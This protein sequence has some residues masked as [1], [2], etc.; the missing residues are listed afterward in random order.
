MCISRTKLLCIFSRMGGGACVSVRIISEM[1][2]RHK[3]VEVSFASRFSDD[4]VSRQGLF[5]GDH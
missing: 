1:E 2:V 5:S 3:S 4:S